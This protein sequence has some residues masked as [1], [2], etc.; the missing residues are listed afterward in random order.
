MRVGQL[1][2][3]Y[4]RWMVRAACFAFI[5]YWIVER[6]LLNLLD[7][8][9]VATWMHETLYIPVIISVL[10]VVV[11][12]L[13]FAL[14]WKTIART[15]PD[16]LTTFYSASSG[17]R[18]L[19]AL[20]VITAYYFIAGKENI[21]PMALTFMAFYFLQLAIHTTFFTKYLK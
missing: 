18:M 7:N 17:L 6:T 21:L 15:S 20:A 10:F 1:A 14:L 9:E 2:A 3:K 16:S 13:L 5:V 19:L 4:F 12:S 11:S 8:I